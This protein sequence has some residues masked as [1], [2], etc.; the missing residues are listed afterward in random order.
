MK[1]SLV[2]VGVIV[3]LGV[4]WTGTAWYTGKQIENRIDDMVK[5]AN[6]RLQQSMPEA[7]LEV[8]YQDYQ[9]GLFRSHLQLVVKPAANQQNAWLKPEQNV[10]FDEVIDHGPFP[11]AELKKFNI[12]PAMA[13]VVSTPVNNATTKPLFDIAK[14]E[15]FARAQTRVGYSGDT[16]T[17]LNFSALNYESPTEKVAFSGGDFTLDVDREGNVFTL[18]GKAASGLI[19]AVN[20]YN[21]R[22][23]F[24]FNGL[25]T[26]GSSKLTDFSERVGG[27]KLTLDKLAIAIE[28]KELAVVDGLS[29]NG[30]SDVAKDGKNIDSQIDYQME[31]LKIQNQDLGSAKLTMKVGNIDGAAWHQ[32]SQ[33]Y[34]AQSRALLG[35]PEIVNNPELYQQR[36]TQIFFA[37]LPVLLK[38][39]PVIT[40]A[41]LSW[42]NAKGESTFNLSLFLKDP[43]KTPAP[44]TAAPVT[45]A[46]QVDRL[47]KS[48]ESKLVIPTDMATEFMTQVAKLEGYQ[49]D[50][51]AK[52]ASQQVKGMAAMGQMFRITSM[53]DDNIVTSLQYANG[54][55]T[56][57]G[58]KMP[59]EEFVGMFGLPGDVAPALPGLAPEPAPVPAPAPEQTPTPAP[60]PAPA[61]TPGQQPAPAPAPAPAPTPSPAPAPAP[62]V[63]QQ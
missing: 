3:A 46:Q 49:Q 47:V 17:D 11:F 10:V 20:E 54:Q 18:K 37:N 1:K 6:A 34:N 30:K 39:E 51:A 59:L 35:Q 40:I 52:L 50:D 27:Q 13:S 8:G 60:A 12:L 62:T 36:A 25:E 63:P 28:G 44:A 24:T 2:A 5:E 33:Q 15:T 22:V 9:R 41:P 21:Q 16:S 42:K 43:A 56:L 26:D 23:Q 57:N 4:V 53:E 45:A 31:S 61:L 32:F 29:F 48:M 14:G 38:G 58:Q 7:G 19:N 55:V